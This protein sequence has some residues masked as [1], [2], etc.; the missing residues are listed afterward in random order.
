MLGVTA[1][2]A[3]GVADFLGGISSRRM[4]PAAVAAL[5]EIISVALALG[6]IVVWRPDVPPPGDLGLGLLAGVA[7]GFG[8]WVFYRALAV[9]AMSLVA[10]ISALGAGIPLVVGL[11]QGERPGAVALIGACVAIVG[12][13]LA[14]RAPGHASREGL[15][16]AVLAAVAFGTFFVLIEPAAETS[17]L[18]AGLAT[19]AS[20]LPILLV[21][22][23]LQAVAFRRIG[24]DLWRFIV[25]AGVLDMVA[26]VAFASATQHGDLSIVSVLA[27]LYPVATVVLAQRVLKERLSRWQAMG[28]AL[29]LLGVALIAT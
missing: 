9:G 13:V 6:A 29:A 24:R 1:G 4:N 5:A 18:W 20:S 14:S 7:G 3:W 23:H 27:G 8:V 25:G 22:C 12:A 16:L 11:A 26:T 17:V 19:R 21:V 15:G 28:V 10:P 2:I